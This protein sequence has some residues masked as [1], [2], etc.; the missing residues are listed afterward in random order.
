MIP[1]CSYWKIQEIEGVGYLKVCKKMEAAALPLLKVKL[2]NFS[3]DLQEAGL[4]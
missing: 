1:N 3:S 4:V 2:L